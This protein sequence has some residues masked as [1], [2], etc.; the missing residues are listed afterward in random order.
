MPPPQELPYSQTL[1]TLRKGDLIRLSVEFKLPV[2]G[3]VVELRDRLRTYI[4][5]R[6]D[7]LYR[8]PRFRG[9]F[10]KPRQPPRRRSPNPSGSRTLRSRSQSP[11]YSHSS[12][13]SF[14]SW[15]GIQQQH[16]TVP[17]QPHHLPPNTPTRRSSRGTTG[18]HEPPPSPSL[19]DSDLD[20]P[21]HDEPPLVPRKF[22]LISPPISSPSRRLCTILLSTH[23]TTVIPL[24]YYSSFYS[25]P[26]LSYH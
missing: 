25:Y 24:F 22:L 3:S 6:K 4:N 12:N 7:T 2:D 18:Q 11:T 20:F 15:N 26:P 9:L 16:P 19:P 23:H 1:S 10:P 8:N 17:Q 13:D 14:E 5:D 21:P